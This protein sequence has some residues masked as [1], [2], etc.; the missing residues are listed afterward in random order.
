MATIC[1]PVRRLRMCII[2]W[3]LP[4]AILLADNATIT[5]QSSSLKTTVLISGIAQHAY[6]QPQR[7]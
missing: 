2:I 1:S 5:G 7:D 4:V 6:A 3:L